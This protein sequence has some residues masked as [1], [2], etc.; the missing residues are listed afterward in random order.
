MAALIVLVVASLQT[1]GA[2]YSY[3]FSGNEFNVSGQ[4]VSLGSISWTLTTDGGYFGGTSEKGF[5]IGSSKKPARSLSLVSTGLTGNVT[6]IKVTTCGARNINA[7][8]SVS[9][10]SET[11]GTPAA[12]KSTPEEL[13]FA[14]NATGEVT[15]SY[16]QTSS[17]ALYISRI[18]ITTGDTPAPKPEAV[19][20]VTSI[21]DFLALPSG[22]EAR[23]CL[24]VESD[25]RVTFVYGQDAYIRDVTGALCL[26]GFAGQGT[27][28]YNQ[29]LAG[30]ITGLRSSVGNMPVMAATEHTSMLRLLIADPVEEPNVQ[31]VNITAAQLSQHYADWVTLSNL[32]MADASTGQDGTG[33]VRMADTFHQKGYQAPAA[34]DKVNASGI[35]TSSPADG[36][37]LSLAANT[38]KARA[39]NPT[40]DFTHVYPFMTPAVTNGIGAVGAHSAADVAVFD[41]SGRRV[42]TGTARLSKGIYIIGGHKTVIK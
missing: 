16:R 38:A 14:G 13:S 41:L 8:L 4:K 37:I 19:P 10:G 6:S 34:G 21:A 25:A 30:C 20:T 15:L 28:V 23:L 31:P 7:T 39:Y 29:H 36:D 32:T 40:I 17:K 33:T 18:D 9:V 22:R 5:Q 1:W 27:M 35:V 3:T 42:T 26:H 2:H 11:F 12:L 24:S